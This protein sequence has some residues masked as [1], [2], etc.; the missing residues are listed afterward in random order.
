MFELLDIIIETLFQLRDSARIII[1]MANRPSTA[2]TRQD[3][4]LTN[5]E[6]D[7]LLARELA[8]EERRKCTRIH[9][10]C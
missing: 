7:A 2:R 5:E 6:E 10:F 9:F 8:I 3:V 4:A 1:K